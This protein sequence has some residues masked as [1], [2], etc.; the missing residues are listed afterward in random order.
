MADQKPIT[1]ARV[2]SVIENVCAMGAGTAAEPTYLLSQ[3]WSMDGT[4]LGIGIN[5]PDH[6]DI[7]KLLSRFQK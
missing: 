7:H 3:Y 5:I 6:V 1:E 4:L 2:I